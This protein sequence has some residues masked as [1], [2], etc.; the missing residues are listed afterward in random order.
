MK[1][2]IIWYVLVFSGGFMTTGCMRTIQGVAQ[3]IGSVCDY[4]DDNIVPDEQ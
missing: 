1:K 4:V 2:L 3:D